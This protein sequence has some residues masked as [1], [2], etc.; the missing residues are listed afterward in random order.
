[1]SGLKSTSETKATDNVEA[2]AKSVDMSKQEFI[3]FTQ[4]LYNAS[5]AVEDFNNLTPEL[6]QAMYEIARK[7][8]NAENG[9]ES[10]QKTSKET[11]KILKKETTSS[12]GEYSKAL[13]GMK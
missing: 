6:Q 13:T 2:M 3:D 7:T 9:F 1:L 12:I 10:L 4:S 8:K 11:W 5:G